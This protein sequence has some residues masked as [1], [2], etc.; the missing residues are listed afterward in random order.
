M[1]NKEDIPVFDYNHLYLS[2]SGILYGLA[3][4]RKPFTD[5][6][7]SLWSILPAINPPYTI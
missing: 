1:K 3:Q 4:V 2:S 6:Y 7:S 5:R